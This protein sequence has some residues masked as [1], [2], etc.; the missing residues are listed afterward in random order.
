[1]GQK[2]V[3][4][5]AKGLRNDVLPFNID[6][7]SFSR[8]INA[9]QWR[10]RIKRKRGTI[11]LGRLQRY[12]DSTSSSFTGYT[13]NPSFTITFD[14]SGNASLL[15]PYTNATPV[16]FSLQSNGSIVPGSII[17]T[18][19]IGAV[20]YTDPTEDGYLTPT[21]TSGPNTINYSTGAVHIPAQA[22]GTATIQMTYYPGLPVMGLED[23][24]LNTTD[25]TQTLSFDT[26]YSYNIPIT[27]PYIPYSVSFYKNVTTST[28]DAYVQKTASTP[29][30]WN[31]QDYQQFW[32]TNY[33]GSLWA[34]NGIE[35]PFDITNVGMQYKPI[36][37]VTV[38]TATTANLEITGHGL[39]VGDFLFINEV[40]TTTGINFQTGYVVTVTDLNNVV[41]KFPNATLATNGT[42]GI[43]QY[44]TNRSDSTK[45]CIRWYD[46]DPTTGSYP[47]TPIPGK[48]WVNF[49]PPL[50]NFATDPTY[51]LSDLPPA[52]Y[53]L[54]GARMIVSYKDRI[55][56]LGPIVQTSASGSQV[57]LPDTIIYSQN[58]T[59]YYTSSF[60]YSTVN[61]IPNPTIVYHEI[62]VPTNQTSQ[63]VAFWGDQAG[64]GGFIQAGIQ[65]PIS[66]V[67]FNEDV[68]IVGFKSRQT[69]LVYTGNDILPFNFFSIN[70]EL[71]SESTFSSIT[72]DRGVITVGGRGIVVTSQVGS[73]RIDLQIPDQIFQFNLK[74][75][76]AQRVCAQRDYI[77]EW[78][79]FTYRPNSSVS[80]FPNQTLFYNYR[81]QSWA[82]FNETYTTYG[83][84]RRSTGQTWD[85]LTEFTWDEWNDIWDS[86]EQ[87]LLQPEVIGGNGQGFIMFLAEGT[88]EDSSGYIQS[89]DSNSVVSSTNH[90]LN[91][92]DY[93][94]IYNCLGTISSQINGNIYSIG[95]VTLNTFTLN[96]V[97]IS[98][99]TYLGN[100]VFTRMY[101]PQIQ[102][103]QF[104]VAWDMARKTR[105]GPQQYLLSKTSAGQITIQIFLS[106]NS[107]DSYNFGPVVPSNLSVNNSLIYTNILYTCP[108][109]TNLGLTTANINLQELNLIDSNGNNTNNQAQIWHRMNT[110]LIGDTIQIGFTLSDEQMRDVNLN[111][112][113]EEIELH[114]FIL[115]VT[116][117]QLLS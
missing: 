78:I 98:P 94:I 93:I 49:C 95:N 86:G 20:V 19:S 84:F 110:S 31:G 17:I 29:L 1:M 112:Q 35:E 69:R 10:Q 90:C 73:Q 77:N 74:S 58:G 75:N 65:S 4:G 36:I 23:L 47:Q 88:G 60:A 3:V 18:G 16:S 97:I 100:G 91:E 38:L 2:L 114:S 44:L 45:D 109:S 85:D 103:K 63:P 102:T 9:Y 14:G 105:I 67:G 37:A 61:F 62:L 108:E 54:A 34:A 40:L 8:L 56:F 41:V 26:V 104:P 6:N 5:P 82:I 13:V 106:Q 87:T 28:Y 68:L 15:G 79:Y 101:V 12:F 83:S 27:F 59:P 113:F 22:G 57:Y 70:T 107:D 111:N 71:G 117:S 96:P 25:N 55:L 72:L 43:A 92:G 51:Y 52:Q 32:T 115:D 21:G 116:P 48:G 46:G 11:Q 66:T 99:G 80:L 42:V 33:Q 39:V 89:I 53:Y 50:N 30:T 64:F 81:D 7:D 76:G 24:I